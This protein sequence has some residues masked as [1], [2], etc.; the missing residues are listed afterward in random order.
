MGLLKPFEGEYFLDDLVINNANWD[1]YNLDIRNKVSHV[2]QEVY[3]INDTIK[4]N[5][6]MNESL[7]K[8][9]I[10]QL[11]KI[12]R[13]CKIA[14]IDEFIQTLPGKYDYCITDNGSNLSGGQKQRIGI[15][16]AI[17]NEPEILFLDES[18]SALDNITEINLIKNLKTLKGIMTIIFVSHRKR[19]LD[20][21]EKIVE[22]KDNTI[23]KS[24]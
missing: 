4:K 11:K 24:T 23:Y 17:Y 18:T 7:D 16:R 5:I 19:P 12:S 8:N 6:V 21:C 15:A 9:D 1:K 22:M 14:S 13:V 20:F 10:M 3:L 2:P